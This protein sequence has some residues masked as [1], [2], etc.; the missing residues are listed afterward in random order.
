MLLIYFLILV[1]N[2][3]PVFYFK[4]SL[5][6]DKKIFRAVKF[7]SMDSSSKITGIGRI[8]RQTAMDELPQLF[9]I[10]KGEM[11]FVGPRNYAV[12]KYSEEAGNADFMLRLKV[13]PGL[14]GPAQVFAPKHASNAEVLKLDIDYIEKRNFLLDLYIISLSVWITLKRGWEREVNKL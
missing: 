1:K 12:D 3:P 4:R 11:S 6:K 13:T 14:T 5:G 9:N 8:L 10:L 7:R 2:G